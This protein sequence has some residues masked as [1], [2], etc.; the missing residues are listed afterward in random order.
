M[1][2]T[3]DEKHVYRLNAHAFARYVV[4]YLSLKL[5]SLTKSTKL[6][7]VGS[8][9][10]WLLTTLENSKVVKQVTVIIPK[11]FNYDQNTFEKSKKSVAAYSKFSGHPV[12]VI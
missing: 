7:D 4:T 5:L 9:P 8:K 6:V 10:N 3:Y 1:N 2:F 11:I 12:T